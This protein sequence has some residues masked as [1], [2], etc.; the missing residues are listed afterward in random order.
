MEV[1]FF[2]TWHSVDSDCFSLSEAPPVAADFSGHYVID[3]ANRRHAAG[4]GSGRWQAERHHDVGGQGVS[5]F[6]ARLMS[7]KD[8]EQF[9]RRDD[10]LR[11]DE[12]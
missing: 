7:T 4:T 8:D 11:S 5:N 2:A 9:C 10:H 12:R 3:Y 1:I 6:P